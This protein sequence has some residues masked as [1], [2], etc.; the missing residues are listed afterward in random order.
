MNSL[1]GTL[2][3]QRVSDIL[4][5]A[6]ERLIGQPEHEAAAAV[7]QDF[8]LCTE[9]LAARCAELRQLLGTIQQS[10]AQLSWSV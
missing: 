10:S 9:T 2:T 7:Q 5:P 3:V 1:K 4:V 6:V 8:P